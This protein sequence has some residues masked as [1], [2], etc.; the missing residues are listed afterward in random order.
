MGETLALNEFTMW[1]LY[2]ILQQV[3]ASKT[4]SEKKK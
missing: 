2:S 1:A 4:D 3:D